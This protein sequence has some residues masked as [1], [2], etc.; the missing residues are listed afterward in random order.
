MSEV[1]NCC[2]GRVV[3]EEREGRRVRRCACCRKIL[4]TSCSATIRVGSNETFVFC[5]LWAQGEGDYCPYHQR[6]LEELKCVIRKVDDSTEDFVER[7]PFDLRLPEEEPT[8]CFPEADR[9]NDAALLR[10]QKIRAHV[11]KLTRSEVKFGEEAEAVER[12]CKLAKGFEN[13]FESL[14]A[15][16]RPFQGL[17]FRM[18]LELLRVRDAIFDWKAFTLGTVDADL[19]EDTQW[20]NDPNSGHILEVSN[21]VRAILESIEDAESKA[22]EE[23]ARIRT[24]LLGPSSTHD[25]FDMVRLIEDLEGVRVLDEAEVFD[26]VQQYDDS[27]LRPFLQILSYL[28]QAVDNGDAARVRAAADRVRAAWN[29]EAT[30]EKRPEEPEEFEVRRKEAGE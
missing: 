5:N 3:V 7:S 18:K 14:E 2:G 24:A 8:H 29:E 19:V 16:V 26:K 27:K 13:Q 17:A 12:V 22:R 25:L 10:L 28:L 21:D 15:G 11:S 1:T 20:A 9:V 6:Q 4:E 30:S 23:L